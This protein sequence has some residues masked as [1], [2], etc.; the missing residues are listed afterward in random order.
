[1]FARFQGY[2]R[3]NQVAVLRVS[4]AIHCNVARSIGGE[5]VCQQCSKIMK[6]KVFSR[7][8]QDIGKGSDGQTPVHIL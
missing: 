7:L 3:E 8:M 5:G 4:V 6:L 1:M 2:N